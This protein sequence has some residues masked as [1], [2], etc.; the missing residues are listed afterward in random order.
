MLLRLDLDAGAYLADVGFGGMTLTGPLRLEAGIEQ[1][2]PHEPFRLVAEGAAFVMQA[3]IRDGWKSLYRFDLQEHLLPDYEVTNWY[4]ANH[5][6]SRF[7]R[8]LIA[9]RPTPDGRYALLNAE[10]AVHHRG[11]SSERHVLEGT[12]ELRTVL[13]DYFLLELPDVPQLDAAL[14]RAL[15]RR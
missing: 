9:A 6:E 14:A 13:R 12:A 3:K 8:N 4:L 2:T 15:A 5:P 7:V 11:G 10:L 1:Q